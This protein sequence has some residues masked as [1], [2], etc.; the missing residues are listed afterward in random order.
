MKW[1]HLTA[2]WTILITLHDG[3]TQNKEACQYSVSQSPEDG[4]RIRMGLNMQGFHFVA[5]RNCGVIAD[6]YFRKYV[7]SLIV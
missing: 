7:L 6:P 1:L 3:V 2:V 4:L 5:M